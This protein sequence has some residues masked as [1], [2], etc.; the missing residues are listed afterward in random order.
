MTH[1][2]T[3]NYED[4]IGRQRDEEAYRR[5]GVVGGTNSFTADHKSLGGGDHWTGLG[6]RRDYT[7]RTSSLPN[8]S[9]SRCSG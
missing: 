2:A 5:G 6:S 8:K 9:S 4:G 1:W 7:D 3:K